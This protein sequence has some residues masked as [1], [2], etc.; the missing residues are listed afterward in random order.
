MSSIRESISKVIAGSDLTETEARMSMSEIMRGG[1]TPSQIASFLTAL[2]MKEET[3]DEIAAFAT[4]MREHARRIRP[5]LTSPLVDTC[6]TGGDSLKIFNVSTIAA[7][8]IS[9]TGLAVAKHGNRSFTS[10]CGSADILERFGVNL[11]AEP[12]LVKSSIEEVGIGFMFAPLFHSGFGNAT[13][14]RREIGIR[15]VFNLLGPLTN[16]AEAKIQL[17][18]VYDDALTGKMAKVL[19]KLSVERAMVVHGLDGLDEI[20]IIGKTHVVRLQDNEIYD[21]ILTP[22]SFG[23][24]RRKFEEIAA[25]LD[26][27]DQVLTT[28]KILNDSTTNSEREKGVKEM[29]LMNAS[30]VLVISGKAKDYIEG[31]EIARESLESGKTLDK[32]SL[33]MT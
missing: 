19:R 32:L 27:E 25:P 21:E 1:A 4:T 26:V 3:V 11:Q 29:I 17:L 20:S 23:L 15:T 31:M 5:R 18:G 24:E 10:K 16:P 13:V 30:A 14:P 9:G 28:F 7:L 33:K 2:R 12:E 22:G 8:V 6:G